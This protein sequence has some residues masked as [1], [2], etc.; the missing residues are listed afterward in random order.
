MNGRQI[1]KAALAART[2]DDAIKLEKA[3][4]S[5]VGARYERAVGDSWGNMGLMA[6]GG[7]SYDLKAIEP[8]TNMQDS[9]LERAAIAKY[10]SR[11]AVPYRSP[12]EA[13]LDLFGVA[14]YQSVADQLSVETHALEGDP[15][16]TNRLTITYRDL[17]AGMTAAEV[18]K[19]I[20]RLGSSN[21]EAVHWQQGAF[22]MGA[23]TT[24]R[25]AHAVV[26]V[27]RK[28]PELLG[29]GEDRVSVAVV[30]W[31]PGVKGRT[32]YY[33]VCSDPA[34]GSS[35]PVSAP[36]A[37]VPG[38]E[39]GTYLALISY[40][41][42]GYHRARGGD[43]RSFDTVLN[44][45]L[46]EPVLPI[47]Y[48][49]HFRKERSDY[50]RGLK[51]RLDDN[52]RPDRPEES[53]VL[54]FTINGATYQLPVR[55]W[56]F[57]KPNEPGAKSKFVAHNHTVMFTSNGQVH[58][59]WTP[60]EFK[61]KTKLNKLYDRILVIVET[62]E[63]PIEIRTDLFSPDRSEL[64]RNDDAIRLQDHVAGFLDNWNELDDI[65]R[66][67]IREA[68]AGSKDDRAT[69][70]VARQISRAL[71]MKGFDLGG[72]GTAG[73]GGGG[74]RKPK[75]PIDL[76]EDPTTLEGP[77]L[78]IAE[79][80]KT[81]FINFVVNAVDDFIPRRGNLEMNCDHPEI[82]PG[83]ITV[84]NLHKGLV[85]V[86]VAVPLNAAEGVFKLTAAIRGWMRKSGGLGPDLIWT[87]KFEVVDEMVRG[88]GSGPGPKKGNAGPREGGQVALIWSSHESQDDWTKTTVGTVEMVKAVDL[89]TEDDQYAELAQLGDTEIPTIQ[90][91]K[92]F[93]GLKNYIG[94]RAKDISGLDAKRD[95]Y[96]IGV[97]VGIASLFEET[98]KR[99]K[100]GETISEQWL[101][102]A[103]L[104]V[105]KSVLAMMPGFDQ[106][107][108]E[109]GLEDD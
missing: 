48:V 2:T 52:P 3:I 25:N 42:E 11:D 75:P 76:Y 37:E 78:V 94:A 30:R 91:N 4:E 104:A 65:N 92:D 80:D 69:A 40:G 23:L 82:G 77:E 70:A 66:Q 56:V 58:H 59:H 35:E 72:S 46:F 18:P 29:L 20:F 98:E 12:S 83:N 6:G 22:G 93:Y 100:K 39:P 90:L 86:S 81:R 43:Q 31:L 33:L 88:A 102:D 55:F 84:G 107:A 109:A 13:A 8:V 99:H 51:Q 26:L 5:F 38:F 67:L 34:V 1:V 79:D 71:N 54:P 44:T 62:D 28:A 27:T 41:V 61:Y 97:G 16:A 85:R 19:T 63:L 108:R 64:M 7:S 105:A 50:L 89:A 14:D 74:G 45:R 95:Q 36:A 24:Y 103:R 68:I 21:K 32:A 101:N 87:T 17:G 73:G 49:S 106:L 10:G 9:V 57:A 53:D 47:R 60:Q 96:A 15:K